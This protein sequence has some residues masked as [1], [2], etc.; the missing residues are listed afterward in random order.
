MRALILLFLPVL[1]QAQVCIQQPQSGLWFED[2]RGDK[3]QAAEFACT[4]GT[5]DEA[6]SLLS[7]QGIAPIQP[8]KVKSLGERTNRL[9]RKSLFLI[10][11]RFAAY[12]APGVPLAVEIHEHWIEAL[13]ASAPALIDG[14][15]KFAEG[16]P[17]EF[18]ET[19]G[20]SGFVTLYTMPTATMNVF[21]PSSPAPAMKPLTAPAFQPYRD[22]PV[23]QDNRAP[24]ARWLDVL[25]AN[26]WQRSELEQRM[27]LA[28]ADKLW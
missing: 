6:W 19:P 12:A 26:A 27:A 5:F 16:V 22:I 11:L 15:I 23:W 7:K 3:V 24:R 10:G 4:G 2:V 18:V 13:L 28:E 17:N 25:A 9:S 20:G 14:G 8:A 1:L 21:G